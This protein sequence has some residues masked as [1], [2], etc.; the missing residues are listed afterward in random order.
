[1]DREELIAALSQDILVYVMQGDF[2]RYELAQK[3]KLE[4]LD[5]RFEEYGLL[6]DLHFILDDD[7]ISFV[8]D[9]HDRLRSIRTESAAIRRTTRGEVRGRVDWSATMKRRYAQNPHDRSVFV[10]EDHA[11][12]YD[13]P[14][15]VVLKAVVSK[16]HST[17]RG[18]RGYMDADY[19]WVRDTWKGHTPLI[20]EFNDIVER[21]VHMLRIRE[22]EAYEP[23]GRMVMQAQNS[24]QKI[25]REA[26]ALFRRYEALHR[27]DPEALRVMLE[28]TAIAPGEDSTLYELF[29]LFRMVSTIESIM[30]A[31]PT[32]RTFASDSQ[33]LVRFDGRRRVV[34]YHD[35]SAN[36]R[37]LSFSYD[38][39]PRE[40]RSLLD[41]IHQEALDV[42]DA[43]FMQPLERKTGR[44]DVLVL[45]VVDQQTKEYEY[46]ITEVKYSSNKKT[47]RQGIKETLEYLGL[48]KLGDD[49][50]FGPT[51]PY[52]RF[53]SG[54]NGLLVTLDLEEETLSLDEQKQRD[55]SIKILQAS[56]LESGL[57]GVLRSVITRK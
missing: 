25:Y 4:G 30:D 18:A 29:V 11:R 54:W 38:V 13:I 3:L 22:P 40:E 47:I 56:E 6:L 43:Y 15:N 45:E 35:N 8:S 44:P 19:T 31:S 55:T 1:M 20:D 32:Y 14:E 9:L 28:R 16:I 12:R 7:V 49:L 23:T 26:S 37:D 5:E 27:G 50:V 53:G 48:I 2:P 41:H 36:D 42:A 17:L 34:V 24:R 21:N 46:L 52:G 39:P 33:E 10:C 51:S 57:E